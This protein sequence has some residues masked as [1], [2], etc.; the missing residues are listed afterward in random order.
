MFQAHAPNAQSTLDAHCFYIMLL[1]NS[2]VVCTR[3]ARH[4]T[5]H[6]GFHSTQYELCACSELLQVNG[7]QVCKYLPSVICVL[8]TQSHCSLSSF[9]FFFLSL[10]LSSF[11]SLPLSYSPWKEISPDFHIFI[12]LTYSFQNYWQ[13]HTVPNMRDRI[14]CKVQLQKNIHNEHKKDIWVFYI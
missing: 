4:E 13:L 7:E 2:E 6:R 10:S 11:M 9:F 8:T 14:T 1:V 3:K 12:S 5:C